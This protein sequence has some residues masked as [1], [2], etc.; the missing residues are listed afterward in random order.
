MTEAMAPV[1]FTILRRY[2]EFMI[3]SPEGKKRNLV[4]A[5]EEPELY[6]HPQAQRT[7]RRVFRKL[8]QGGDQIIFSTHSSLLLDVAYFDEIIRLESSLQQ[9]NGKRTTESRAWQLHCPAQIANAKDWWK[10]GKP[11]RVTLANLPRTWR[12]DRLAELRRWGYGV[13]MRIVFPRE[14]LRIVRSASAL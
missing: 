6:M 14:P 11:A 5:I 8:A 13:W 10:D 7:I 9:V 12:D 2:A 1:I 3:S 4:L